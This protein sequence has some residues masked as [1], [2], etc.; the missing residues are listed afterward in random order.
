[1]K[2]LLIDTDIGDDIDDALALAYV[3]GDKE[4][5]LIAVT[6]V[7]RKTKLRT[8]IALQLLKTYNRFDIPVAT[9]I[10]KPLIAKTDETD[11][12]CQ[13]DDAFFDIEENCSLNAIELIVK[14]IKENPDVT[15]VP[16]GP[17]TN[18]ACAVRMYPEI[19]AEVPL[20]IM[21]G[22]ISGCY[23]EWNILCDPEA[24]AI[25]FSSC[26][27]ITMVGL[28]VTE[29]CRLTIPDVKKL[30]SSSNPR[31]QLLS[32]L[33]NQWAHGHEVAP[34]LHDPL[35][36]GYLAHPELLK[37]ENK[38]VSIE[39]SGIY[40]RGITSELTTE[41]E[42]AGELSMA[43]VAVEVDSKKFVELFMEAILKHTKS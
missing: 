10:E 9:G 8:K 20:I 37:L 43:A 22:K 18:I 35:T 21:G 32:K 40:S 17:L 2:K 13:W 7:F 11:V 16:I 12:P 33:I 30:D 41:A 4:L 25:V 27:N 6:T 26:K 29:K 14:T 24:A 34:V 15:I 19:M 31:H 28:D 38:H 1:M 23:P 39:L 5:D 3:L 42:R 36:V